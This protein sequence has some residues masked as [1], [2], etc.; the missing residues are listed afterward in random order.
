ME[1]PDNVVKFRKTNGNRRKRSSRKRN[2][3]AAA[4]LILFFIVVLAYIIRSFVEFATKPAV[5]T[6]TVRLGSIDVPQVIRGVIIRDEAVYFSPA[7]GSVYY[8]AS[9]Y[10]RVKKGS[11]VCDIRD[12]NE[13]EKIQKD[14][15]A[16]DENILKLQERRQGFSMAD[17]NSQRI[18]RQIK[19]IVDSSVFLFMN[20]NISQVY[21]LR[22]SIDV[23]VNTRNLALLTEDQG[24]VKDLAETRARFEDEMNSFIT[25]MTAL[26]SGILCGLIDGLEEALTFDNMDRLT[27]EQTRPGADYGGLT[28]AKSVMEG[29]AVFKIIASNEWY[30]AAYIP[31]GLSKDYET[32]DI[33]TVYLERNGAYS[34]MEVEITLAEDTPSYDEKYVL[35]KCTKNMID[36]LYMRDVNIKTSDSVVTGLKI[37]NSAIADK[38]LLAIPVGFASSENPWKVI[39]LTDDL[40][41]EIVVQA[42]M[43]DGEYIYAEI[44]E[45]HLYPGVV[46]VNP[47]DRSLRASLY[48]TVDVRGVYRVNNGTAEF[49]QITVGDTN[50]T[51][52]GY[53]LLDPERNGGIKVYDMIVTD[54]STVR[55]GQIIY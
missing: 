21:P 35:M 15:E 18:N 50:L 27:R 17:A 13:T 46:L 55:D 48:E 7:E 22:E 2:Y 1:T 14:L 26:Q 23:N 51:N 10:D 25:R 11:V 33:K 34:P 54:A 49:R 24:S 12:A 28:P 3:S 30:I 8:A 38:S 37:S 29:D 6:E 31:Y 45:G 32:G 41:E 9:E 36:Y 42:L 20:G 47:E 43:A 52:S 53:T 19:N 40:L 39:R 5:G 4:V 44:R 16:I